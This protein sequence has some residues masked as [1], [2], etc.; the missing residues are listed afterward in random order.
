VQLR[1]TTAFYDQKAGQTIYRVELWYFQNYSGGWS[2]IP[3]TEKVVTRWRGQVNHLPPVWQYVPMLG[4][5]KIPQ[6]GLPPPVH[7]VLPKADA[8]HG[9][10]HAHS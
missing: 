5:I 10:D 6:K 3:N 8:R 7:C 9:L 1:R 2:K 4:G